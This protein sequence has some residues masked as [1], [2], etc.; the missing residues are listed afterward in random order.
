MIYQQFV[1]SKKM[2][3]ISLTIYELITFSKSQLTF[4]LDEPLFPLPFYVYL[5]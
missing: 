1:N 3:F 4:L 5:S 2:I